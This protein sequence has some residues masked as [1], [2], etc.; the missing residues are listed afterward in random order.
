MQQPS[1]PSSSQS[2]GNGP[3]PPMPQVPS[4]QQILHSNPALPGN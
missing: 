3:V 2:A 4:A 1:P